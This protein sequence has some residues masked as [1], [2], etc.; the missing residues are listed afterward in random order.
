M[1]SFSHQG[2]AILVHTE[3]GPL[4]GKHPE[5]LLLRSK[6]RKS[7][8]IYVPPSEKIMINK[9][10]KSTLFSPNPVTRKHDK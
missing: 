6:V 7:K 2:W 4:R 9:S 5:L 3:R 10:S 8:A 1:R